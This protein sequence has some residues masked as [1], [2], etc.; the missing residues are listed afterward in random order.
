MPK[1]RKITFMNYVACIYF[2]LIGLLGVD[3][4]YEAIISAVGVC[5]IL[6]ILNKKGCS[7]TIENNKYLDK[8]GDNVDDRLE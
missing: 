8:D 4:P 2:F 3:M 5:T 6:I 7:T 1:L